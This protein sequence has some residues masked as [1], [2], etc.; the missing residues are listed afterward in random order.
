MT[1]LNQAQVA[2][3]AAR[4]SL[5]RFVSMK[6]PHPN[7]DGALRPEEEGWWRCDGLTHEEP[8]GP[9]YACTTVHHP[10]YADISQDHSS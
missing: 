10:I 9:L 3:I 2:E 7:C 5:G 6:C 8:D 4:N 1:L